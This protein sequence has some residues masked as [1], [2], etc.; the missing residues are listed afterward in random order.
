MRAN[1]SLTPARLLS[2]QLWPGNVSSDPELIACAWAI[3]DRALVVPGVLELDR[4]DPNCAPR[5]E[6]AFA[7]TW[8]NALLASR[9][10]VPSIRNDRRSSTACVQVDGKRIR[11]CTLRLALLLELAPVDEF[12]VAILTHEAWARP[13]HALFGLRGG[14]VA[15]LLRSAEVARRARL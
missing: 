4:R 2:G 9:E 3:L 12:A 1:G 10:P 13:C 8:R 11:F 15:W 7:L 5:M 6:G 14:R